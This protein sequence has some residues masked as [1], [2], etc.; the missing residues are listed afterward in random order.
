M[1]HP[2]YFGDVTLWW[3]LYVVAA[4][5]PGGLVPLHVG[6]VMDAPPPPW[7]LAMWA[8]FATTFRYSLRPVVTRPTRAA[9]LGAAGGHSRS[10]RNYTRMRQ[11]WA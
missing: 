1:R 4:S 10:A 7:L 3:G 5:T 6:T 9:L 11:A 2:N 8:Q